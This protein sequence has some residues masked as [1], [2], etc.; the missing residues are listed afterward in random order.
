MG[1]RVGVDDP[2]KYL[3][4]RAAARLLPRR[5][6]DED[7]EEGRYRAVDVWMRVGCQGVFLRFVR[8]GGQRFTTA[9]WL[10]QFLDA[11]ER[12]RPPR[13]PR[14]RPATAPG[15]APG[16]K[17]RRRRQGPPPSPGKGPRKAG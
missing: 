15:G 1:F 11:V 6:G 17:K 7:D 2:S 9:D 16:M 12:D 10:S 3:T 5:E 8:I 13:A 4:V 14:E